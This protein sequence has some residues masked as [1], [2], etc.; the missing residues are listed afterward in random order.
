VAERPSDEWQRRVDEQVTEVAQGLLSSADAYAERLW[1]KSLRTGT[2]SALASFEHEL[3]ALSSP[4]D[5]DI[6]DVV[7]SLV[8]A[9]NEINQQHVR[10]G[11]TGYETDEREQLCDYIDASLEESG[12]D[13]A[14]LEARNSIGRGGIADRWRD[15]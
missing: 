8:L 6:L 2:D 15:W 14:A 3:R 1:P 11:L 12:V 7:Q 13:L 4:A 5:D 9:L 10:A